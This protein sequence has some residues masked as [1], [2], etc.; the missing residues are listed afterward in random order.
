MEKAVLW[1]LGGLSFYG[2]TNKGY[3]EDLKVAIAGPIMQIPLMIILVTLYETLRHDDMSPVGSIYVVYRDITGDISRLFLA[4]CM[5]TFWFNTIVCFLNLLIPIYPLDGVR[6]YAAVLKKL[7]ASLTKTAKIISYFGMFI[8]IFSFSLGVFFMFFFE[9]YGGG[10]FEMAL[11]AFGF[12]SSK[13]LYDKVKAGRLRD[14]KIFG[15]E[16]I[17]DNILIIFSLNC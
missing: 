12:A 9:A 6:I 13:D 14:D 3:M 2:P 1:P 16:L 17:N 15:D 7:G 8:S 11:G 4:L 10:L 5:G